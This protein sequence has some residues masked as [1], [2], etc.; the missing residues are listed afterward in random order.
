[1]LVLALAPTAH[2]FGSAWI[3]WGWIAFDAVLAL[4][5]L[6][7]L[8]KPTARSF[9]VL[10]VAVSLDAVVTWVQAVDVARRVQ[11]ALEHWLLF[12]ACAAPASA[13]L[14]LWGAR[15]TRLRAR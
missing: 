4:G 5:F 12:L 7:L 10:A 11:G 14:L 9:T 3:K 6:R 1:M 15:R 8:R 2:W 13:A